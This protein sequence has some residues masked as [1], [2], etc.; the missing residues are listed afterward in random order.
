MMKRPP[1][2][3]AGRTLKMCIRDRLS[4]WR[5]GR[6]QELVEVGED[7]RV[8]VGAH[9]RAGDGVG[10]ARIDLQVVGNLRFD[11]LLNKLHSVFDVDV[12]VAGAVDEQE[13]AL[14][15]GR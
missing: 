3:S 6:L 7:A 15:I 5:N 1:L 2:V 12:V 8:E 10:L 13:L 9:V 11:E 14:Q 4:T